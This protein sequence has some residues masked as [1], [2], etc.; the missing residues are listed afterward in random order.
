MSNS[1]K[2]SFLRL[3]TPILISGIL[4]F[5]GLVAFVIIST[6]SREQRFIEESTNLKMKSLILNLDVKI[7]SIES[8]LKAESSGSDFSSADTARMYSR[9]AML[10]QE[11]DFT[12]DVAI[13]FYNENELEIPEAASVTYYADR[14]SLG[15]IATGFE[16][17][18][19][20]VV[21]KNELDCYMEAERTGLPCWSQPY[22][23]SLFTRRHMVTCYQK[24]GKPGV[25]LSADVQIFTLLKDID[26]L[27]FYERGTLYLIA[28][29]GDTYTLGGNERHGDFITK[30][31]VSDMDRDDRSGN[32]IISAHYDKLGIDIIDVV[33]REEIHTSM[34]SKV[35][36][37]FCIF[38]I[39]LTLLAFLVHRDF[40]KAQENLTLS[41]K[42]AAEEERALKKIENDLVIAARIQMRML[43][44][45]GKGVHITAEEGL[46][47]DIMSRIIPA[48]EVGGDLYAYR[49]VGHNLILCIADVSGKGIPASVLMTMCC[50]LFNAYI[51]GA[52]EYDPSD[53]L[54]YMNVQMCPK[55]KEMMFVTMWAG[56]LDLR[57]GTLKYSSAGHNPPVLVSDG[58]SFLEMCQG[59]PLGLF[60]DAEF[61]T[62]ERRLGKGDSLVLYTDGI[63]EA[64][65]A[66]HALFGEDRLLEACRNAVSHS[67]QVISNSILLSVSDH[68]CRNEQSDDITLLCLT[69]GA[70]I[71]Q[72]HGIEN[73][74]VLDTLVNECGDSYRTTLALEELAVNAFEHGMASFVSAECTDGAYILIDDGNEFDPTLPAC[75]PESED[76]LSTGGRGILLVKAICSDIEYRRVD[77]RFNFTKLKIKA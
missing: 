11:N 26:S 41:I 29:N 38:F 3:L 31:N 64:E 68:V 45:P 74:D 73:M 48:R 17:V 58:V 8:V 27:Q 72:L 56:V 24:S 28:E 32:I 35:A 42:K 61:K 75:E 4:I 53:L 55:N 69:W 20:A 77:G 1:R 34:W 7:S 21:S 65:D 66:S 70:H 6:Y 50:T 15:K 37:I 52:K 18:P 59:L 14:D 19:N 39:G 46:P 9:M 44:S 40:R 33:P 71:A 5:A 62:A 54:R 23:D 13:D 16:I 51:T 47:S 10:V 36:I 25:M 43:S 12:T 30:V 76:D 63:T 67:P 22:Y 49:T 57:D 60:D 2:S